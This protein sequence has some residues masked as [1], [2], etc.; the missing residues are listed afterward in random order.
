MNRIEEHIEVLKLEANVTRKFL[1]LVPF[2][3]HDFKPNEKSESLGRLAVHVAEIIAW[4][5]ACIEKSELDFIDF[6]PKEITSTNE[7]LAYFDDLFEKAIRSLTSIK[8]EAL[9]QTWTMRHGETIYFTLPKKQVLQIFCLHHLVHHR[10]QLGVYLRI[11]DID[12][13]ATYGPS[14]D[15]EEV[16]LINP[17]KS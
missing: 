3:K 14:A 4:W 16:L 6:E 15:D 7:L 9:E 17:Y 2:N 10:A 8:P 11:L 12:L 1:A 13:P 5:T